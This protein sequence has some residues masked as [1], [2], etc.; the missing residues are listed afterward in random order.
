MFVLVGHLIWEGR[1][2]S[3]RPLCQP[4]QDPTSRPLVPKLLG[5]L[6]M[7]KP[8]S[9]ELLRAL[10]SEIWSFVEVSA[11]ARKGISAAG[12]RP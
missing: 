5:L 2:E 8:D 4:A 6:G 1:H 9:F 10:G 3:E 11:A 12:Q 7:M